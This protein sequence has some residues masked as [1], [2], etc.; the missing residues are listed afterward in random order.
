MRGHVCV[1][2]W[3][4]WDVVAEIY[5]LVL[6]KAL[7]TRARAHT[8]SNPWTSLPCA[9]KNVWIK[10]IIF[11][12]VHKT[13]LVPEIGGTLNMFLFFFSLKLDSVSGQGTSL[14]SD[15]IK[16]MATV[17][18]YQSSNNCIIKLD[19]WTLAFSAS[20][21]MQQKWKGCLITSAFLGI[22]DKINTSE[23]TNWKTLYANHHLLPIQLTCIRTTT[24]VVFYSYQ[25]LK[26][27]EPSI[28]PHL[29]KNPRWTASF[30]LWQELQT[31]LP[32]C[33][34]AASDSTCTLKESGCLFHSCSCLAW[35]VQIT[36]SIQMT[37]L[38]QQSLRQ[39][40]W[41]PAVQ[42]GGKRRKRWRSQG[43]RASKD[44]IK[45]VN[46]VANGAHSLWGSAEDHTD[47]T[48]NYPS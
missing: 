41:M 19:W 4:N 10:S 1:Y 9:S 25:A 2:T 18:G 12:L 33:S 34:F 5:K 17:S 21:Q 7:H 47:W 8:H 39:A 42:L 3:K 31:R 26:P 6:Y 32:L 23:I 16:M 38:K 36:T 20:P 29:G 24:T 27:N 13:Q 11:R 22:K 48:P 15:L 46:I 28:S 30:I 40:I 14:G 44:R 45:L 37:I 43:S 35:G